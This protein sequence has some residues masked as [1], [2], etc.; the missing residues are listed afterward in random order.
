MRWIGP[1]LLVLALVF[2]TGGVAI[3]GQADSSADANSPAPQSTT[4][5]EQ[6][7]PTPTDQ[8]MCEPGPGF[9][10]TL[11]APPRVLKDAAGNKSIVLNT[12][13]YNYAL[14]GEW[15]PAPNA[16]PQ[17]VPDGVLPDGALPTEAAPPAAPEAK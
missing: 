7:T 13:G 6:A 15:R 5:V 11:P 9:Q 2:S 17:G 8:A 1:S 4:P 10:R 14:E 16:R 3:V 12:S